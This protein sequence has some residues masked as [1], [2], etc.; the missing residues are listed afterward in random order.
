MVALA[1]NHESG[2]LRLTLFRWMRDATIAAGAGAFGAS[3]MCRLTRH[4]SKRKM[5]WSDA[6]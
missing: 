6:H 5:L 1:T 3:L 4:Q 2:T